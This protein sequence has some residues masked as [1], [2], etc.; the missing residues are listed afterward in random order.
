MKYQSVEKNKIT[1]L[2][3]T[4]RTGDHYVKQNKSDKGQVPSL[5]SV[6]TWKEEGGSVRG[7]KE[8]EK[9][10]RGSE[11]GYQD[12]QD[13]KTEGESIWGPVGRGR[14]QNETVQTKKRAKHNDL[15]VWKRHNE[16]HHFAYWLK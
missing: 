13:I 14:G 3:E 7:E 8:T 6:L 15:Y 10:G 4:Q 9:E 12:T 2:Q 16:T 1:A 5:I 11:C